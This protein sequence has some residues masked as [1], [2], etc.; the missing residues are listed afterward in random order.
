MLTCQQL[1]G[2]ASE[3]DKLVGVGGLSVEK[4]D[5]LLNHARE[6]STRTCLMEALMVFVRTG[7][8]YSAAIGFLECLVE[9]QETEVAIN[10]DHAIA[11]LV[12]ERAAGTDQF[13]GCVFDLVMQLISGKKLEVALLDFL[14]CVIAGEGDDPPDGPSEVEE[15]NYRKCVRC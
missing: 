13:L 3:G 6:Q 12:D 4:V 8:I 7:N 5:M 10:V 1:F 2:E 9:G 11:F 14:F 15:P